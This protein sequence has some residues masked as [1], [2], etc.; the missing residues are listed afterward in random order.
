M[1]G[2]AADLQEDSEHRLVSDTEK[3]H[4]M[5]RASANHTHNNMTAA[6][7]NTAG[8]AGLVPAPAKGN[9]DRYLRSDGTWQKPPNDNTTYGNMAAASASAAGKAGLVPA[10]AAGAQREV[11]KRRWNL[12]DPTR[13]EYD[14]QRSSKVQMD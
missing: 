3:Q 11:F 14:L 8:K 12:A 2:K 5:E 1:T 13:H 4:G 7:Q 9:A 10:P 6:T